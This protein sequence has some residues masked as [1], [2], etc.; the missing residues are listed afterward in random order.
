MPTMEIVAELLAPSGLVLRGGFHL[1]AEDG[2]PALGNGATAQSVLM[3]GN[4]G[5]PGGDPMWSAFRA[6]RHRFTGPNPLDD[7]TRS[8]VDKLAARLGAEARY[9]FGGPPHLPFQRW[10]MRAD[11]V[12]SSPLGILV[13]PAHGLWHGYRAALLFAE[14]LDLPVRGE[15]LSPCAA[16]AAKPCLTACPVGAFTAGG[17]DVERCAAYLESPQGADCLGSGCRARRACPVAPARAPVPDQ[18]RFHMAAFLRG[19]RRRRR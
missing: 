7:W 13:H 3:I 16:C 4:V 2:V 6:A 5:R 18:A 17:Y 8:I 10:A 14:H 12:F 11:S 1:A 19:V 15:A 9:P